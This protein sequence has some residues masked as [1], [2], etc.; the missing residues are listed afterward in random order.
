[1]ATD[2]I[3]VDEFN[4]LPD[5]EERDEQNAGQDQRSEAPNVKERS[6]LPTWLEVDYADMRERL[7]D[8]M[9][10]NVSRRPSCYV[11]GSFIDGSPSPFL[12]A[13]KKY[14]IQPE[15]FYKPKYFIWIPHTIVGRIPC[16][17]CRTAKNGNTIYLS[18]NSFPKSPRRVVDLDENIYIIGHRY[19]CRTCGKS[20]QSWSPALLNV[21]PGALSKE[22]THH[23]SYRGGLTGRLVALMRGCFLQGIGPAPFAN[24]V[25]MNHLRRYEQLH[26]QYLETVYSRSQMPLSHTGKYQSFSAFDDC[27]GYAGYTPSSGYFRNFYVNYIGSHAAEMDQYTAML[28]AACLQIDHSFKV[29]FAVF[30]PL[31]QCLIYESRF[32]NILESLMA[33]QYSQHFTLL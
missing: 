14:Q 33:Y 16:P 10:K 4:S 26:L 21:L 1:M 3:A 28:S 23:L 30:G 18:P 5:D 12:V 22:F 29:L 27:D 11:R 7:T 13:E 24:L 8:E 19:F 17:G 2:K 31:S 25:R 15:V 20:Y 9:K 6:T 32:R